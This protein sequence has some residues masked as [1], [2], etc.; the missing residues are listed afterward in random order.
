MEYVKHAAIVLAGGQG[1]RMKSKVRKQYLLVCGKPVLWYSLD[2]FEQCSRIDEVVLVCGHGEIEACR[3]RFVKQYGF[4]KIKAIVEGGTER[5]HSVLAGLRA[6]DDA[7]FVLIHDGARPFIDETMINRILD[8]L[9][10]EHACVAGMPVKDTIKMSSETG[11]VEQTLPREKLWM[12]QTPQAFEYRLIRDAYE[13]L[14]LMEQ[15]GKLDV[16]ITDDAMVAEYIVRIPVK[17]IEGSY[18]NIK[19]TTPGDLVLAE[20]IVMHRNGSGE[21]TR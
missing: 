15:H 5:Y 9:P 13:Q 1:S 21:K 6:I 8:L 17:L 11:Y 18:D 12:I 4:Q 19:I 14:I 10:R 16:K 3:E 20:A 7:A 2:V